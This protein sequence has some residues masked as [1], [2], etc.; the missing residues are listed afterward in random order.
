MEVKTPTA[1]RPRH[2]LIRSGRIHD[3]FKEMNVHSQKAV[4]GLRCDRTIETSSH[5]SEG[6]KRYHHT[7]V[8]ILYSP[9]CL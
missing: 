5:S 1:K 4:G 7:Y 9:R 2:G 8:Y 3:L 6:M